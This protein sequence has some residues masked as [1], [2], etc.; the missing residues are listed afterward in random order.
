MGVAP[1][2][3]GRA[4]SR[5]W[6]GGAPV[7][8][9]VYH[10][11][12]QVPAGLGP[13]VVTVGMFDGVHRG[14]KALLG[15]VAGEAAARG[16]PAAAV[17]FDRHPMEVLRPGSHP[18]LLTT[19]SQKVALL[20]EAGVEVV[21]VLPFTLELSRVPA[22]E[23]A[24]RVLFEAM[25]ARAVVV[26]ANFRF[27]HKAQGDVELLAALGRERGV[28][29]VGVTLHADGRE[30]ISSTRIRSELSRGDVQA[31]ARSLGRP[32]AVEGYVNRGEGRGRALGVPTANVGVPA[33]IALPATGV[34]AG[35]FA[36]GDGTWLPAVTNVG[37]SPQFGGT[38]LRVEAHVLDYDADLYGRRVSVSFE[39]RLR[40]EEVFASVDELVDQMHEDVRQSRKLLGVPAAP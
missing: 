27:G 2:A 21:L 3:G 25:G 4:R 15:H 5:V 11:L 8:V 1:V 6:A 32:Y 39:H 34:Y 24:T 23:F 14:H 29:A 9:R 36:P 12:D 31:A 10:G 33:R 22:R 18:L 13:T 40:G 37:V 30:V 28:D 26:G 7:T 16:V 38:Q 17:T 35:H 20:G 19:L